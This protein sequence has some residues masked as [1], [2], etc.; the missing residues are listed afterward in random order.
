MSR[1]ARTPDTTFWVDRAEVAGDRLRLDG[2]ESRH[3][4]RVFRAA[5]GTPFEAVDGEGRLYRCVLESDARGIATGRIESVVEN[6]GE[7]PFAIS[8]LAGLP[9][10]PQVETLVELAVPLGVARIDLVATARCG[11]EALPAA[12][13]ERLDRVARS[14]LKQSRRTRLPVLAS[15]NGLREAL[16]ALSGREGILLVADPSG[17]PLQP[18]AA[19]P[20]VAPQPLVVLA[21]GPPGG[22]ISEEMTL[23]RARGF[24][25]ISLGPSRLTTSTAALA[26]LAAVRNLMLSSGLGRV[27]RTGL[28]GYL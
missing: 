18:P 27:D 3:L 12:R 5:P 11:R 21:V 6:A 24:Q 15:S 10:F 16:E 22:F 2:P 19:Q 23:L 9:D 8:V 14:A 17:T 26:L 7:L 4:L 1:P 25:P 13:I 20:A 28:S